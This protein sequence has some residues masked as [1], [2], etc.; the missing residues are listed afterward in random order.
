MGDPAPAAGNARLTIDLDALADNHT[1]LRREAAGAEVAPVL[2]SDGYGLGAGPVGRRLWTEGARSFFVARLAEGEAL[3]AALGPERPA[4]IYV[5]DGLTEGAADRFAAAGLT[6]VLNSLPQ[7]STAQAAGR[8]KPLTVALNID[9]G[10]S[11]QGLTP[12]EARALIQS[13]DRL[14]SL[15]I[16]LVMSHMGSASE[17]ENPRNARQLATF[18]EVKALF[19]GARASLSASAGI[20]LNPDYRFD[21]VRPGISLFGGGPLETP[22]ARL[23]AV[24]TLTAPILD[25]RTLRPGD[26]LGYGESV[27]IDASTRVA[28]VAAGYTDGIIRAAKGAGYA[29]FAGARRRLLIVNMDIL[30]VEIGDA[31]A[32]LGDHV[33]LLGENAH[34]D[35]LAAAGGTVAHEILVRLSRRA[36]RVYLG[37]A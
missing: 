28:V 13:T 35:D 7:V 25:I 10:M 17:V 5:L 27:R 14:R 31:E 36:E 6:P 22:D 26:V 8:D 29:W 1:V 11:R 12:D 3:R 20:F 2:K 24:A 4:T 9:T 16:G 18:L 21:L 15:D 34:L 23:R 30:V 33:E 32:A 37:E 19:P